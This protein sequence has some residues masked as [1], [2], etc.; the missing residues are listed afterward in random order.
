MTALL[1]ETL[2]ARRLITVMGM[3]ADKDYAACVR[4]IASRSTA[5]IASSSGQPRSQEAQV[6][7]ALAQR[8]CMQ[9][10]ARVRIEDA[11]DLALKLALPGDV[12]LVCGSIYNIAPARAVIAAQCR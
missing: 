6:L 9:V 7:A 3:F 1:D 11:V 4:E 5:F 10:Y 2:G 8:D 12:V